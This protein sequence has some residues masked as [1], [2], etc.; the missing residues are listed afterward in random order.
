MKKALD[1]LGISA[2]DS[3][4]N[5]RRATDVLTELASVGEG[6]DQTTFRGILSKMGIDEGTVML[7]LKGRDAV[8]AG[9]TAGREL[10]FT[11]EDAEAAGDFDDAWQDVQKGFMKFASLILR[12]VVP[13]ITWLT[14][15]AT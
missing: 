6:M 7:L 14:D 1:E 3:Q 4:G 5:T 9:L 12:E 15:K 11:D 10:A 13:A 2:T 8:E